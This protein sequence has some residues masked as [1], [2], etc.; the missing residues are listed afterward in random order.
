M[1]EESKIEGILAFLKDVE[2]LKSTLRHSWLSSGRRESVAEHSWRLAVMAIVLSDEFPD[3]DICR[4]MKMV[5]IHDFGETYF[6]DTP[7]FKKYKGDKHKIE[8]KSVKKLI[9]PLS[10]KVQKELLTIWT[11]FEAGTTKE[12]K[13]ALALDKLEVLIQHNEAKLSSWT[14]VEYSYNLTCSWKNMEFDPFTKAFRA[15]IDKQIRK[16][17]SKSQFGRK[18]LIKL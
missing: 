10:L 17:I 8:Q 3:T 12:A 5:I 9:K 13:L 2:R 4:V 14:K 15:E 6:G 16:K 7:S 18:T 11:E 1:H